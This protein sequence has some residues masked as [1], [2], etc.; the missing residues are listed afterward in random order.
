MSKDIDNNEHIDAESML[1]GCKS[2]INE[3][4]VEGQQTTLVCLIA[5]LISADTCWSVELCEQS[6]E[7]LKALREAMQ[8]YEPQTSETQDNKAYFLE[9]L[10]SGI[11]TV[12]RD[13]LKFRAEVETT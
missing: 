4:F 12:E 9:T 10:D 3:V 7:I 2:L 6:L 8:D 11:I 1:E 5:S 13:L